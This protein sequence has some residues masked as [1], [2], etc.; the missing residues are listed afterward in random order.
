MYERQGRARERERERESER[1][2]SA[3]HEG[4][5]SPLLAPGQLTTMV[6]LS[7]RK[8]HQREQQSLDPHR[9]L[10]AGSFDTNPQA[11]GGGGGRLAYVALKFRSCKQHL[12]SEPRFREVRIL[13]KSAF[14]YVFRAVPETSLDLRLENVDASLALALLSASFLSLMLISITAAR[15]GSSIVSRNCLSLAITAK[16]ATVVHCQTR[17]Q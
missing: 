12:A 10:V 15:H 9:H 8:Y 6:A 16:V 17:G 3:Q 1:R 4:Y 2:K 14:A 7:A 5:W 13:R 11:R